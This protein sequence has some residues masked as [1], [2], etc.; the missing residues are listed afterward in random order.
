MTGSGFINRKRESTAS[1]P[2]EV[3]GKG[4]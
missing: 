4:V 2:V 1:T 3:K